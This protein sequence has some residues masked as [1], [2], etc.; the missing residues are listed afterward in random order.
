MV[1]MQY[2][3]IWEL[4]DVNILISSYQF[5]KAS[6]QRLEYRFRESNLTSKFSNSSSHENAKG[7]ELLN[8]K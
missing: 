7:Y 8:K 4:V 3:K 2:C 6:L 1:K 5:T